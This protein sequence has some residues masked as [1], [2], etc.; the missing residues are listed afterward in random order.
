MVYD[1]CVYI[2]IARELRSTSY[3]CQYVRPGTS[4]WYPWGFLA[5]LSRSKFRGFRFSIFVHNSIN[6]ALLCISLRDSTRSN[7]RAM[8]ARTFAEYI[9]AS[10]I[11]LQLSSLHKCHITWTWWT[12]AICPFTCGLNFSRKRSI[13]KVSST[14]EKPEKPSLKKICYTVL[15]IYVKY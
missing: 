2:Y 11:I 6:S 15:Y 13:N 7:T 8:P 10:F 14:R 4:R 12:M 5:I 3:L 9:V 1:V